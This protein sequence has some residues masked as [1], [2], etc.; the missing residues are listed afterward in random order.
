MLHGWV[1]CSGP[2]GLVRPVVGVK[3]GTALR[4]G[5]GDLVGPRPPLSSTSAERTS[6]SSLIPMSDRAGLSF[7]PV[8]L[9][10]WPTRA[11]P[12]GHGLRSVIARLCG[13][14]G[15]LTR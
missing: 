6:T 3:M 1:G 4:E 9:R 13:A 7:A 14:S 5:V 2:R 8:R 12:G 15:R 11:S 10:C